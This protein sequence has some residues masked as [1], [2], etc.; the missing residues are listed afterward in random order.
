MFADLA[1]L[2]WASSS[3]GMEKEGALKRKR[4]EQL[5]E[6]SA[7]IQSREAPGPTLSE[8]IAS[9]LADLTRAGRDPKTIIESRQTLRILLGL[10]GDVP[11]SA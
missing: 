2:S 10:V 7:R 9:H 8:A 1:G 6:G 11:A 5:R 3:S 4:L